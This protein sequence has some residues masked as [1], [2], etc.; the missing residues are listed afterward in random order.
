[1]RKQLSRFSGAVAIA[2]LLAAGVSQGPAVEPVLA[3]GGPNCA[4]RLD[5]AGAIAPMAGGTFTVTVF[6]DPA[7]CNFQVSALTPGVGTIARGTGNTA[8][9]TVAAN[10]AGS[11]AREGRFEIGDQVFRVVQA[12][13]SAATPWHVGDVFVG[14]G[15]VADSPGIYKTLAPQGALKL[16]SGSAAPA[17]V[18]PDLLDGAGR[19]TSGCMVDPTAPGGNGHLFT[20]SWDANTLSIFD[21][22]THQLRDVFPF[23]DPATIHPAWGVGVNTPL[24]ALPRTTAQP[25]PLAAIGVADDPSTA[26]DEFVPPDIQAFE[27]V[28]FADNG[29]FYVGTQTPPLANDL[30]LGHGYLLRFRYVPGAV[31]PAAKLTLTG[32]WKLDAGALPDRADGTSNGASGVDQ[33]DLSSDQ[34]TIFYTSEDGFIRHFNVVTGAAGKIRLKGTDGQPLDVHAYGIRILPGPLDAGGNATAADGSAGFLVATSNNAFSNVVVRVDATG[35]TLTRYEVPGQPFAL[36]LAPDARYLWTADH[37]SGD[38]YRFHI[39]SGAREVF[40]TGTSGVFGLCVKREYSAA[41]ADGQCF[42]L[43]ADGSYGPETSACRTAPVCVARGI[44][45]QGQ[46]NPEC[47]PP[48]FSRPV[49]SP[50]VNREGE[51]P[52]VDLN[53]PG[54]VVQISGLQQI[55]GLSIRN[56]VITGTIGTQTC[57]PGPGEDPNA[58]KTCVFNLGVHW[59]LESDFAAGSPD[60]QV[61]PFTWS[62]I[63]GNARP[64]L[65]LPATSPTILPV[66][67]PATVPLAILDLDSNDHVLISATGLPPGMVTQRRASYGDGWIL[68]ITGTPSLLA[69]YPQAFPVHIDIWDCSSDFALATHRE[70]VLLAGLGASPATIDAVLRAEVAEGLEQGSCY[71]TAT[72]LDFTLTVV[73]TPPT[74]NPAAQSTLINTPVNYQIPASDAEGHTLTWTVTDLPAGL[75]ANATGLITGAPTAE[76]TGQLVTVTVVDAT[77]LSVT[78]KFPWTVFSNRAPVCSTAT[79]T[80]QLLWAPNHKLVPFS[81]GNV[82]DPDGDAVT[83]VITSITQNQPVND[84]GDGNTGFDATGVGTSSG[85]VRA[86]RTGHLRVPGDGRVYEVTF[87][88]SDGKVGGTCGGTVTIGVPHDQGRHSVPNVNGCR[89]DSVSGQQLGPC[90]WLNAPVLTLSNRTNFEGAAI[91]VQVTALDPDGTPLTYAA[92]NLPPGLSMS[93]TGLITGTIASGAAGGNMRKYTVTVTVSDGYG[94]AKSTFTWTVARP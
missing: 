47:F 34:Q 61:S 45:A 66:L 20:A 87:T 18:V 28:V 1:M 19:F 42:N 72:S 5:K 80:P 93:S 92:A 31:P 35:K 57:T 39:A 86:E 38:V 52:T 12:G 74:L 43:N 76:V 89:W 69:A 2:L 75:F 44:D 27:Q 73:N 64:T 24:A 8:I 32:W 82:T 60:W 29:D 37:E 21:A 54:F 41:T 51:S 17:N 46:Q 70:L 88:A 30:G 77:G 40:D 13:E 59:M 10:P 94:T 90:A 26:A 11:A 91:H 81:I 22:V 4:V 6:P 85:A 9:V 84:K 49:Y 48:G 55:P 79:V 25:L 58:P 53:R 78:K 67:K 3:Q 56:G 65:S 68:D 7:S 62:I 83:I 33:F 23:S 63:H 16:D 71:H 15:S 50:L 36:N 14:A